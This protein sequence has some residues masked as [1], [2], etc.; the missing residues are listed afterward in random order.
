M[1]INL[2][3]KGKIGSILHFFL[4]KFPSQIVK[5]LK[6]FCNLLLN[7]LHLSFLKKWKMCHRLFWNTL[8]IIDPISYRMKWLL[9][10]R[11]YCIIGS[12]G[13]SGR[14]T[15]FTHIKSNLYFLYTKITGTRL[16]FIT[17]GIH[18]GGAQHTKIS[19][20][21]KKIKC[22]WLQKISLKQR[23]ITKEFS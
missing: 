6:L 7:N 17:T 18:A 4:R 14:C 9:W 22:R 12:S 15:Y 1:G 19:K 8:Y 21:E 3:T 13:R 11:Y 10:C 5:L 23:Q 2:K 20:K 16:R